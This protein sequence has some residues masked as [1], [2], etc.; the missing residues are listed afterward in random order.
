MDD[1]NAAKPNIQL[2][3]LDACA[4]QEVLDAAQVRCEQARRRVAESAIDRL[5]CP[6]PDAYKSAQEEEAEAL[7]DYRNLLAAYLEFGRIR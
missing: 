2:N 5:K 6:I 4:W 3:L 7:R 1:R